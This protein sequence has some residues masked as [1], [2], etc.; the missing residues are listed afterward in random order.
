[1][2]RAVSN[3]AIVL[4]LCLAGGLRGGWLVLDWLGRVLVMFDAESTYNRLLDWMAAHPRIDVDYG[5]W[6]LLLGGVVSLVWVNHDLVIAISRKIGLLSDLREQENGSDM[7][8]IRRRERRRRQKIVRSLVARWRS[9]H[10]GTEEQVPWV[11]NQLTLLGEPWRWFPA[12]EP[13]ASAEVP[14]TNTGGPAYPTYPSWDLDQHPR[15][16]A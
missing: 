2:R 4:V 16:A 15:W 1:M 3:M 13:S 6:I 11:N 7:N 14:P 9:E 5:P 8:T 10:K 12:S